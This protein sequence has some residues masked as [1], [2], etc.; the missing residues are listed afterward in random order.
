M[1]SFLLKT[2]LNASPSSKLETK[3][4]ADHAGLS[5]LLKLSVTESALLADKPSKLE[6]LLRI[7]SLAAMPPAVMDAMVD[8]HQVLSAIGRE[9]VLLPDGSTTPPIGANPTPLLLATTT[10][11]VNMNHAVP[12]NQPPSCKNTCVA[13]YPGSYA[14]DKWHAESVYSVPSAVEKIQTEIMTH[15]PVEA[16]FTVYND[17]L[18]YKSGVYQH[19]TGSALG[20]HAIKIVGWGVESGT[21]YWLVANS[22]NEDWGDKGFFKIKRGSNECGIEGQIVAGIPNIKKTVASE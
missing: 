15:G 21:P 2:G 19:K 14:T 22:W 17:F 13:G 7:S 9:T 4:L 18:T 20:G 12:Q 16:A 3:V 10:P 8:T 5:V 11:L 6:S 1:N